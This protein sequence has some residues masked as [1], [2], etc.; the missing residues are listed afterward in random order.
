MLNHHINQ[1]EYTNSS[2][3]YREKDTAMRL[4]L[5]TKF[6]LYVSVLIIA[7]M[8][9]ST[10]AA[11]FN[12]QKI[13]QQTIRNSRPTA[14]ADTNTKK[15]LAVRELLFNNVAITQ[16]LIAIAIISVSVIYRRIIL[17]PIECLINGISKFGNG[18]LDTKIK[19]NTD[20]EF[21]NLAESF[22]KM[23]EHIQK[24]TT[25]IDTLNKQIEERKKTEE[26]MIRLNQNLEDKNEELKNF[27]Y[28]ASHDLREPLRKVTSFGTILEK[29]L[30]NKLAGDDR[31]NLHIM[32][33]GANRMNKMIEGLLVYSRVSNRI[34]PTENVDLNKIIE[35]LQQFELAVVLQ[36]KQVI[37]NIPEP[38]PFIKADPD[39]VRELMQNLIANG[40]KYQEPGRRPCITITSKP[41]ED[42]L[43]KI[44]VADNGIGINPEY[45][46]VIFVMFKR[47]HSRSQYEGTGI[48]LAVCK[49]IVERHGG[50]IG[51]ESLEGRGSTFW[52]TAPAAKS[53]CQSKEYAVAAAEAQNN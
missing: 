17:G 45:L 23:A 40:I 52:F 21:S 25:S 43:L 44:E 2:I 15:I 36:E 28:I 1:A 30:T 29:S 38:L 31:E 53:D 11:Y 7:V 42:G 9:I 33:D 22:N 35:Q 50:Q 14:G 48:G 3:K 46:G 16:I 26:E 13:I 10:T 49:K 24:T 18:E 32:I 27:V 8:C 39:Q 37:I 5:K 47:L 12:S 4:S 20:D 6:L 19:L 51:V 34:L 41:A